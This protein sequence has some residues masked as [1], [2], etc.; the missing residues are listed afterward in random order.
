MIDKNKRIS[1]RDHMLTL[2]VAVTLISSVIVISQIQDELLAKKSNGSKSSLGPSSS[3]S[4][5]SSPSGAT[6][7]GSLSSDTAGHSNSLGSGD[8]THCDQAGYPSCY[9]VG[10]SDGMNAPGTSCPSGH[11]RA[12][13]DGYNAGSKSGVSS[14]G[15]RKKVSIT[16]NSGVNLNQNGL[17]Y[18]NINLT[19]SPFSHA[20]SKSTITNNADVNSNLANLPLS[21]SHKSK[22]DSP[23]SV[24]QNSKLN[25]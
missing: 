15:A 11:S 10:Y 22:S 25:L 7:G 19:K 16:Q 13:C 2:F 20:N 6:G 9:S 24:K 4:S 23:S 12:Y 1:V 8:P 21:S 3:N 17:A 18:S 14:S 5:S